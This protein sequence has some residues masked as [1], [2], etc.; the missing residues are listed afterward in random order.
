M[1]PLFPFVTYFLTSMKDDPHLSI[2]E[3]AK[4]KGDSWMWSVKYET[5]K[6]I[7]K[8]TKVQITIKYELNDSRKYQVKFPWIY[9]YDGYV[10]LFSPKF[11]RFSRNVQFLRF[12]QKYVMFQKLFLY[13]FTLSVKYNCEKYYRLNWYFYNIFTLPKSSLCKNNSNIQKLYTTYLRSNFFI[14]LKNNT[15]YQNNSEFERSFSNHFQTVKFPD[16]CNLSCIFFKMQALKNGQLSK[17]LAK[18]ILSK[19]LQ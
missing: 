19:F 13:V 6:M 3:V 10:Y 9:F 8:I 5:S 18:L 2:I 4:C 14:I 7:L 1:F 16:T 12:L 11:K 15:L 17:R